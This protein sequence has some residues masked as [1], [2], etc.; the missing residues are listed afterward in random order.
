[1]GEHQD[2]RGEHRDG[3]G[4]QVQDRQSGSGK[5]RHQRGTV[6]GQ[7]VTPCRDSGGGT[8]QGRGAPCRGGKHRAGTGRN[9]LPAAGYPGTGRWQG[10]GTPVLTGGEGQAEQQGTGAA[11][12]GR[13]RRRLHARR[14]R[15]PGARCPAAAAGRDGGGRS[16]TAALLLLL[17]PPRLLLQLRGS[18]PAGAIPRRCRCPL[19][20]VA[21][22]R[23][24]P[25]PARRRQ[26]DASPGIP[27]D[28]GSRR[29]SPIL[30]R[31]P[32]RA[33][34]IPSPGGQSVSVQPRLPKAFIRAS[35]L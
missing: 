26:A 30:P 1:M 25:R 31:L 32:G 20:G 15:L 4:R 13:G 10:R 11:A 24:P 23:V 35:S 16:G 28:L 7:G 21:P 27:G 9:S 29:E 17:L 33:L 14:R 18:Q 22:T 6:P 2:R 12:R 34:G 3:P 8:V 5:Q 19:P